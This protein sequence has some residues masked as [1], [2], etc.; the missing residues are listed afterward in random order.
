MVTAVQQLNTDFFG[1]S[2]EPFVQGNPPVALKNLATTVDANNVTTSGATLSGV[3]IDNSTISGGTAIGVGAQTA[4]GFVQGSQSL[5]ITAAGLVASAATPMSAQFNLI[6]TCGSGAGT[7]LPYSNV[8]LG[9]GYVW[10]KNTGASAC[11]LYGISGD[12]VDG[13]AG[14]TGIALGAG[15]VCFYIPISGG[16]Q[17]GPEGG[18]S[19]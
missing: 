1:Q 8:V 12:T 3:T 5:N 14:T 4:S 9:A 18:A 19:V 17:T 16:Y 15:H 11:R 13:T 7:A 10:T 2:F 6:T